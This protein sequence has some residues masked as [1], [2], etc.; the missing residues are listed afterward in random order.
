ML[1]NKD[2]YD[3]YLHYKKQILLFWTDNATKQNNM[4]DG[5]QLWKL[6]TWDREIKKK[7]FKRKKSRLNRKDNQI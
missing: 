4:T 3:L 1:P 5:G 7:G 6:K 2:L